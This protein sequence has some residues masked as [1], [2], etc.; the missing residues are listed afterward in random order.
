LTLSCRNALHIDLHT[1]E[2]YGH[3]YGTPRAFVEDRLDRGA[4]LLLV[5]DAEGRRKL[6]ATHGP[7]RVSVFLLPPSLAELKR[8]L[9]GRGQDDELTIASR[10]E[11][12]RQEIARSQAYDYMLVNRDHAATLAVLDSI[13]AAERL[14]RLRPALTPS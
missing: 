7:G 13:L 2:L 5:L 8:R 11:A 9:T 12:A 4:D 3:R 1:A 6:A 14:R 10:L